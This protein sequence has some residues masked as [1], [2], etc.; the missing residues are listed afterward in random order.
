LSWVESSRVGR[1][2]QGFNRC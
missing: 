2:E 1:S